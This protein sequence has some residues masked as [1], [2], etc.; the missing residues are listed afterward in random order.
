MDAVDRTL[1][2]WRSTPF[3]WG[4]VLPHRPGYGDCLLSIGEYLANQGASDVTERFRGTYSDEAGALAH[5]ATAGGCA[6][7]IDLTGLPRTHTPLRGDVVV[8]DTGDGLEVGALCTGDGI[9]A[10]LARGVIEVDKRF[11][12]IPHAWRVA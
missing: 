2:L 12:R 6:A 5:V 8:L 4:G 7:L 1:A 11:L 3:T 10:R 9:A